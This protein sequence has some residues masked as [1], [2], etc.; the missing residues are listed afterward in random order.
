MKIQLSRR[1]ELSELAEAVVEMYSPHTDRPVDIDNILKESGIKLHTNYFDENFD[2]VLVPGETCFHIHL[3]LRQV[4]GNRHSKRAR[5]SIAHE[6]GHY[7]IDEHRTQ[8]LD[9]TPKPSECGLF[10]GNESNEENEA[11]YFAANLI[12]PPSRFKAAASKSW[13]PLHT[14]RTLASDF[15]AS[16]TATAL[17]FMNHVSDRSM[18]IRWKPD[19]E[20][21][22]AIPG[23]GYC[24]E[25][26]R[27]V[28]F[29]NRDKL[30]HDSASARV[31]SGKHDHSS[32]VL[33]MATVFQNVALA[34]DRNHLLT[35]EAIALGEYGFMTILSD[36]N[37]NPVQV[38]D[39]AKRR[40]MKK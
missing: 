15:D 34:G 18:V 16:L 35:E 17:Q 24:N 30:P 6:L 7:F 4:D 27:V 10:D 20:M 39:R 5:F 3:N 19:G 2:A 12:M 33:D 11:D 23:K 9:S 25:G 8:L 26:Y 37:P 13:T 14:I 21:A 31:I 29:K 40:A 1:K 28:L 22:W 32:G 36:H 38:T